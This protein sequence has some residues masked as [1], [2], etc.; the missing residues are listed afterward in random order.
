MPTGVYQPPGGLTI[1]G[2]QATATVAT[3]AGQVAV[4]CNESSATSCMSYGG[5]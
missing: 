2:S 1:A 5:Q 3:S 4:I